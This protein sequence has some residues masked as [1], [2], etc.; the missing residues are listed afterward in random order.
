MKPSCFPG[1]GTNGTEIL[2]KGR[3]TSKSGRTHRSIWK[4][5]AFTG[6]PPGRLS[7]HG[8]Y[9]K[10]CGSRSPTPGTARKTCDACMTPSSRSARPASSSPTSPSPSWY[11]R[12]EIAQDRHLHRREQRRVALLQG[13]RHEEAL[14]G[15]VVGGQADGKGP[16]HFRRLEHPGRLA[17][18]STKRHSQQDRRL[19]YRGRQ[20][21]GPGEIEK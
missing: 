6:L 2:F 3:G 11:T 1:L 7:E 4:G 19:Q 17:C 14:A 8:V 18:V 13:S 15:H 21:Q 12:E 10:I 9:L 5:S 16:V 20:P